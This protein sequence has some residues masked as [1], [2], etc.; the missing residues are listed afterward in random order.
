[1]QCVQRDM[2]GP[3]SGGFGG[4]RLGERGGMTPGSEHAASVNDPSSD[5]E[6]IAPTIVAAM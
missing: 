6:L 2:R 5:A 3:P 4:G 1:M